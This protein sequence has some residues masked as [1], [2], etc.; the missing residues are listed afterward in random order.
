MKFLTSSR[1]L[2]DIA[3]TLYIPY[4]SA[5]GI[6]ALDAVGQSNEL[7]AGPRLISF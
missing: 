6:V 1:G 4:P 7:W 5:L 2:M 3:Q